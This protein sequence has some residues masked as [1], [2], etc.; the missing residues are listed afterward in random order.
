MQGQDLP[1]GSEILN[2][3]QVAKGGVFTFDRLSI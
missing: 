2:N 3:E 1:E